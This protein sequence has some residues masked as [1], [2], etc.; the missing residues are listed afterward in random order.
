MLLEHCHRSMLLFE[1]FLKS[2]AGEFEACL[3]H[4]EG[5]QKAATSSAVTLDTSILL[6][7]TFCLYVCVCTHAQCVCLLRPEVDIRRLPLFFFIF[8][9]EFCVSLNLALTDW[10]GQLASELWWP[11][12]LPTTNSRVTGLHDHT[13]CQAGART[14]T[15]VILLPWQMVPHSAISSLRNYRLSFMTVVYGAPGLLMWSSFLPKLIETQE[16]L[17]GY[18]G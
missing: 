7:N 5:P 6:G 15:Q 14:Q 9:D 3:T 8:F 1:P 2:S 4:G 12:Y 10:L 16:V 18:R 11:N 13:H 17:K